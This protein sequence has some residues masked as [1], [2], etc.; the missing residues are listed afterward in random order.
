MPAAAPLREVLAG[1]Q[2]SKHGSI[3]KLLLPGDDSLMSPFI[4]DAAAI[5]CESHDKPA[6]A[7]HLYR[8][9][10][11]PIVPIPGTRRFAA[12]KPEYFVSWA[13]RHF[14][15]FK[16]RYDSGGDPYDVIRPMPKEIA[17]SCLES[18]DFAMSMPPIKRTFPIP[19]PIIPSDG[20]AMRL[21]QPGYDAGTGA[22]VFDSDF[23]LDP[24]LIAPGDTACTSGGYYDEHLTL[25][26]AVHFLHELHRDFPFSDWTEPVTPSE[27]NPFCNPHR[28]DSTI[29]FSRSL[30][31]Q[32]MAMLSVFAAG[33]VPAQ[34]SRLGF[35]YNANK[36]RSGKTLLVKI[37]ITA[38]YGSFKA[39]SWRDNEDDMIKILDSETLAATTYI[40]FDNIRSLIASAPLEGFMTAPNWTGRILGRSEMFEA[41]NNAVLFFTANNAS[42]GPDMQERSLIVD[43]YVETADRQDRGKELP[44]ELEMDDVWLAQPGNRHKILSALW[45][46]VRHWDAAGRPLATGK[47]RKGFGTWCRILGGM[48]EFAGF[49][50]CLERPRNLENCGDSETDDIRLLVEYAS[51][52][53]RVSIL[54]FQQVV[55]IC[56]EK[57]YLP[58]CIHGREEFHSDVGAISLIPNDASRS[59]LGILLQRNCSGERG[60]VHVFKT[61]TGKPR[62]VR[63]FCKGKGR[64]RRF[65]F[66]EVTPS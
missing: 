19:V 64:V 58:W 57:G 14:A 17:K 20:G 12:M 46:I 49:G 25:H 48:V 36:Q 7:P 61:D 35:L 23:P 53:Q 13:D 9:D 38:I 28:P 47:P 6:L 4:T 44:P 24:A 60:E 18:I 65:H 39:Q 29:R 37:P 15:P 52:G 8:R 63:F 55:H 43:L 31:V 2:A 62:H 30:S 40:C 54:S 41:E 59:R 56:W 34:A 1:P 51:E 3:P 26:H 10:I 16:T 11:L 22:F 50:D 27:M 33:C 66:E 32:I 45:A 21:C 5:I 42:L